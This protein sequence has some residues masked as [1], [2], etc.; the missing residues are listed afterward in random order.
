M[1]AGIFF[2]FSK[3]QSFQLLVSCMGH[4]RHSKYWL[5]ELLGASLCRGNI[6]IRLWTSYQCL[7]SGLHPKCR[8]TL[9]DD[10]RGNAVWVS[11]CSIHALSSALNT[12][13]LSFCVEVPTLLG[14][15]V[16]TTALW[17]SSWLF[18]FPSSSCLTR[19]V[20]YEIILDR[21]RA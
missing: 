5:S 13:N 9:L 1:K 4:R 17:K 10:P 11:D 2:F 6:V 15:L 8:P 7:F 21:I 12:G 3:L 18:R 16:Y 14:K 19:S 20:L